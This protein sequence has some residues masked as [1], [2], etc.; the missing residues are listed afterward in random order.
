MAKTITP[1]DVD[2]FLDNMAWAIHSTHHTVLK[3]SPGAAI[4]GR[5]MLFDITFIADWN[6]IGDYRQCQTDLSM[7]HKNSK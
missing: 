4:F 6:K 3:A 5:N 1:D 7:A 2:V